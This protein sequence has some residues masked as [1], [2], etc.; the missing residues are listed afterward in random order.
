[1]VSV[2]KTAMIRIANRSS[3]TARVSRKARSALGREVPITAS[4]ASANAMS[5]AVGTAQPAREP[6]SAVLVS[7]YTSA[8]TAIPHRAATTG[9]AAAFGSRRSPATSSRLSSMP[10]TKKKTASSPSAAQ[11][12]TDRCSP[13]ASGPKWKSLTLS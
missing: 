5:V 12:A 4:T 1:M 8:G 11:C 7:V 6:A 2:K 10:A 3:T 9:R 13:R